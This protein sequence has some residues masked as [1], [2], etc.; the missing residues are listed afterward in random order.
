MLADLEDIFLTMEGTGQLAAFEWMRHA[1]GGGMDTEAALD[2]VM[3]EGTIWSQ[4]L[5]L[6]LLLTLDRLDP[7]WPGQVF[8]AEPAT[9]YERLGQV[10]LRKA[11]LP[12]C[13]AVRC[14]VG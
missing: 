4:D 1:E 2:F 5:G 8:S 6:A 11:G 3:R 7:D 13:P 12:D 10:L 14:Q 9:A